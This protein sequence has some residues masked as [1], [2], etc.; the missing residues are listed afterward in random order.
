MNACW[1]QLNIKV[2]MFSGRRIQATLQ[3]KLLKAI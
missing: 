3:Y 2:G 1:I